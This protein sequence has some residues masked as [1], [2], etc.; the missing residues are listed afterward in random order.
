[1]IQKVLLLGALIVALFGFIVWYD[2][3]PTQ[4]YDV[5]RHRGC[6]GSHEFTLIDLSN[7]TVQVLDPKA[8]PGYDINLV[9]AS[10]NG[11]VHRVPHLVR[12]EMLRD[13]RCVFKGGVVP[14]LQCNGTRGAFDGIRLN[15]TPELLDA[16]GLERALVNQTDV[17]LQRRYTFY[18]AQA[19][20]QRGDYEAALPHY[21]ARAALM[22]WGPETF[23]AQHRAGVCHMSLN[24]TAGA[25]KAFLDAYAIDPTRKEPLYYLARMARL[26]QD[27]P[28]CML[29]SGAAIQLG[30][31]WS[32][33][34]YINQAIYTWMMEDE[35]AACLASIGRKQ[36]AHWHWHRLLK[37]APESQHERI[38]K[39]LSL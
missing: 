10:S 28:L 14:Y 34:L 11:Q 6:V 12:S 31:A 30:G 9:P 3:Q 7:F 35:R 22:G 8:R 21:E 18:L 15:L 13:G 26:E 23:Y 33:A 29:Y 36:D 19:H 17:E 39:N 20:E 25:K 16:A 1:M 27:F 24:H 2:A 32:D 4:Y 37:L 5:C 38:N